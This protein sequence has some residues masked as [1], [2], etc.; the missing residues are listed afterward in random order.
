MLGDELPLG[1]PAGLAI[2]AEVGRSVGEDL[3]DR[4]MPPNKRQACLQ[5][6]EQEDF[7]L[8]PIPA[9]QR[10]ALLESRSTPSV[11]QVI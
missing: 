7:F 6:I 4:T 10:H 5:Q 3:C 8:T 1:F 11:A 9:P 2:S